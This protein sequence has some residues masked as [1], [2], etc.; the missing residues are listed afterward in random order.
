MLLLALVRFYDHPVGLSPI[1]RSIVQA[2]AGMCIYQC[3]AY[4]SDKP[5]SFI[6]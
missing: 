2:C 1:I 5:E 4:Y 6:V 3:C